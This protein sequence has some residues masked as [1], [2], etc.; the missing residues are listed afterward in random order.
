MHLRNE[1]IFFLIWLCSFR[2]LPSWGPLRSPRLDRNEIAR[3]VA[4][5]DLSRT[6]DLLLRVHYHLLPLGQPADRARDSK[7]D[8]EHR[9]V[10]THR[11]VDDPRV[12]VHVG[13][14][15]ALDEV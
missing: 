7:Q 14:K 5:V 12:E 2:F 13:V 4:D 1:A 8:R 10:E 11:L 9:G 6:G 15:L 3:V